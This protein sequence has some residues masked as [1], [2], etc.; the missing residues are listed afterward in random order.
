ML[1]QENLTASS[2]LS[3]VKVH[4]MQVRGK[5]LKN[6]DLPCGG[7][8][9]E[10]SSN[11]EQALSLLR[12]LKALSPED[13]ESVLSNSEWQDIKQ[14]IRSS[15]QQRSVAHSTKGTGFLYVPT[16]T[17]LSKAAGAS[18]RPPGQDKLESK[19][20]ELFSIPKGFNSHPEIREWLMGFPIGWTD[21]SVEATGA[22][23]LQ[24]QQLPNN[25]SFPTASIEL[26]L[27]EIAAPHNKQR[28][29][30]KE[31]DTST[32]GSEIIKTQKVSTMVDKPQ[33]VV[34]DTLEILEAIVVNEVEGLHSFE[35]VGRALY[36]IQSQE[37]YKQAQYSSF[38]RYC[39]DRFNL[40][41]PRVYQLIEAAQ[42]FDNCKAIA[43]KYDFEL[44]ERQCRE[45]GKIKSV[46]I[47]NKVLE[48]IAIND[49]NITSRAIDRTQKMFAFDSLKFKE[50]GLIVPPQDSIVRIT[51]RIDPDQTNYKGYWGVVT[52]SGEFSCD[53]RVLNAQLTTV[54]PQHLLKLPSLNSADESIYALCL[55]DR[56]DVIYRST[57]INDTVKILVEAIATRP[58]PYLDEM[59]EVLLS[60]IESSIS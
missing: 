23:L 20:K 56:L 59:D 47:Q 17:G 33:K 29:L 58:V 9:C 53:V 6:P 27:S 57:E 50:T 14:T 42:V 40:S 32:S 51:G 10:S 60:A 36:T 41:R 24:A 38:G 34:H 55:L 26:P 49:I 13:Y 43:N 5:D 18:C 30:L 11:V 54:H 25:T 48:Q 45:L 37:L 31:S 52:N 22:E 19:L 12:T 46:E 35:E 3:L 2:Q 1:N 21:L 7:N 44:N 16:P 39:R 28:S 4:R 15:Y 8:L